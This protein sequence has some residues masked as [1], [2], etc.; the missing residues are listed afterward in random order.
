M[1]PSFTTPALLS[2]T[3]SGTATARAHET[4]L[5]A[6][7][8]W[9]DAGDATTAPDIPAAMPSAMSSAISTAAGAPH[10]PKIV[11]PKAASVSRRLKAFLRSLDMTV[12]QISQA[13]ARPPF[14]KGTRAHIRDAFY[15]EI[16]SGQTPD[17]HQIAALAKLTGYRF[18][19]WLSLFGYRVDEVLRLQ[20]EL[21]TERTVVLPSTIYDPLVM[22]PWIRR[23]DTSI[24][25]DRTQPLA[26][27]IDAIA[28]EPIGG[29]DRLNRRRY[30]YARV[31]RRDDMVRSRLAAGSIVRVDPT[32]TSVAPV[33]GPR[34]VYL[35]QHLG[36][37]CCCYVERLDDQHIIL[38]PDDGASRV[39]RCRV[40]VEATILGTVD[41]ELRSM[42]T[43]TH[44]P[45][46][47]PREKCQNSHRLRPFDGAADLTAGPG[48]YART[49]RE[50]I[51]VCFREAQMMTRQLAARFDDKNYNV[52]LGSLS[53]AETQNL[54]PRHIPKIFSL[55]IA[56]SMDFWQYLRAGGVAVDELK[57]AAIPPQFLRDDEDALDGA[58]I[59]P[60]PPGS[61]ETLQAMDSVTSRIGEVPFFLLRSMGMLVGQEQLSLDDVYVW[62]GRERALHPLLHGAIL[63]IVN[64]RQRRVPDAR[65]RL[66]PTQRPLFLIRTPTGQLVAGMCALDGEV[67]LVHPHNTARAPV[68]TFHAQDVEVIGRIGA[69]LRQC[70]GNGNGESVR[71]VET[72]TVS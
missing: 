37:L 68:L 49:A 5:P 34:P 12:Y 65:M 63:L 30:I 62:G 1:T 59:V 25:L 60:A 52:A 45:T 55:C 48:A 66:S 40:G 67:L 10:A 4:E 46:A 38:L 26:S 11:D 35:V 2:A 22:L 24:D 41:L 36:G 32:H 69:V 8:E 42:Q 13:T 29:L 61:D 53:D 57:G 9:A 72:R 17:I 18:V 58:R 54:L 21:Q 33:G 3:A 47:V 16:E 44:E 14:G 27:L 56:Y 31:G 7:P 71:S 51:G 19:D 23:M 15:A 39:M 20:L 50:R 64:R 43:V 70:A 6:L 28:Y